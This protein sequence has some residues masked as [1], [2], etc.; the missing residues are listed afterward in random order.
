MVLRWH[1]DNRVLH[2]QADSQFAVLFAKTTG[3]AGSA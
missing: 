3:S 1:K 2:V